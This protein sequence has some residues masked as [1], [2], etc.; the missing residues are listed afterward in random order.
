M[1]SLTPVNELAMRL[2]LKDKITLVDNSLVV[3]TEPQ[4]YSSKQDFA[5]RNQRIYSNIEDFQTKYVIISYDRF[6]DSLTEGC[7]DDPLVYRYYSI[8]IFFEYVPKITVQKNVHNQI[9]ETDILIREK[10]LKNREMPNMDN[11]IEQFPLTNKLDMDKNY[12]SEYVRDI[13]G[14][15]I[16]NNVKISFV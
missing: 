16:V 5:K 6:S 7:D 1:S 11:K 12:N 8:D 10:F 14:Y 3:L 4:Y 9:V 2:W 15:R 13:I